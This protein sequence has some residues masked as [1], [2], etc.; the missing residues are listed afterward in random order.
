MYF[1][2]EVQK[3]FFS[4][5]LNLPISRFI[6]IHPILLA[7]DLYKVSFGIVSAITEIGGD[8]KWKL[9]RL[10]FSKEKR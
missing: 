3:Y 9:C 6:P 10:N 4:D 7:R 1:V 2:P 8:D 5:E